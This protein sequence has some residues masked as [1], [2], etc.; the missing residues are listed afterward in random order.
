MVGGG[1]GGAFFHNFS[2]LA[3]TVWKGR[4]FEDLEKK[5]D[6]MNQSINDKGVCRTAPAVQPS[7]VNIRLSSV[8]MVG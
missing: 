6:S 4:G 7:L 3:L 2:F 1:G 8:Q 5:G